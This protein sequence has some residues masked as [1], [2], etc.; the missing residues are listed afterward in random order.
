MVELFITVVCV[1]PVIAA[2]VSCL[3]PTK[4]L[5][6]LTESHLVVSVDATVNLADACTNNVALV[7][8]TGFI[9]SEPVVAVTLIFS[10][11]FSVAGILFV[12]GILAILTAALF[13]DPLFAETLIGHAPARVARFLP[14]LVVIRELGASRQETVLSGVI[15]VPVVA[16][17]PLF[18]VIS[19][20]GCSALLAASDHVVVCTEFSVTVIS[21]LNI[22]RLPQALLITITRVPVK[23]FPVF[24]P[25]YAGDPRAVASPE[26]SPCAS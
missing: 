26:F 7:L 11:I 19:S 20:I 2:I 25:L 12:S 21:A 23:T 15:E 1:Q 9:Y 10:G 22:A 13:F 6:E 17:A 4:V 5:K 8:V 18:T 24:S 3:N 14:A 16:G